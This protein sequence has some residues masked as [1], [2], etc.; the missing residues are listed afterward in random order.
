MQKVGK[1]CILRK[2]CHTYA[3]VGVVEIMYDLVL[4]G[5]HTIVFIKLPTIDGI[6]RYKRRVF[7]ASFNKKRKI[8]SYKFHYKIIAC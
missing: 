8:Y 7:L 6:V 3:Y 4:N 5:I 2:G 1:S